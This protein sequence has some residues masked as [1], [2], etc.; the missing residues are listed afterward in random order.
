MGDETWCFAYNPK[1]K[2]LWEMRPGVLPIT[3]KQNY[4]GR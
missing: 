1:T 2:L 4:Y 3:P